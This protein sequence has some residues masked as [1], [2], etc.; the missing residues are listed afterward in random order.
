MQ[1]EE[2]F[3]IEGGHLRGLRIGLLLQRWDMCGCAS[4]QS[5]DH[6][7]KTLQRLM[8]FSFFY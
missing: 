7:R 2:L 4:S 1:A 8:I 3:N 5:D 6:L